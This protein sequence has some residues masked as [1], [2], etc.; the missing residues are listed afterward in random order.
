MSNKTLSILIV[1]TSDVLGGA[2][3]TAYRLHCG[4]KRHGVQSKMF[5]KNKISQDD[6]VI[7]L[8]DFLPHQRWYTIIKW[9]GN[10]IMN[11]IQHYHWNKY[12]NKEHV[13][14]SDLRST[15]IHEAFLKIE[16]NIL[17]LHWI[18]LRFL[19]LK[20]LKN[21]NKP[22]VWTLH[23][24]W[25]FTGV[26]HYFYECD[27]YTI[28]CG[29]C[30]LLHSQNNGDLSHFVWEK[31]KE[32]YLGLN[33]HI[34]APSRWLGEAA[35]RSSLFREFPVSVIPNPIDSELFSPGDRVN[36]C[37]MLELDD[38]KTYVLYCAMNAVNDKNKGFKQLVD[39]VGW[40][41]DNYNNDDFVLLV[42]GSDKPEID[43]N[44]PID[45]QYLG[46]INE[47][48]KMV[49]AYRSASVIVV[50]SL[51]ENL[52]NVIME[53]LSCGTPV[54]AFDIGGNSD[55]IDHKENGYLA[56]ALSAEDL[57]SGIYWCLHTEK[58][59]ISQLARK[60]VEENFTMKIVSQQYIDLY[61]SLI[62]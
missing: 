57:A 47:D 25:P 32:Y 23:D 30:P 19:N 7:A 59:K 4:M 37:N 24:C 1:S 60:K 29:N 11:K 10:K 9:L 21:V 13:F 34:V 55:M 62:K 18:N 58:K 53:S 31:K 51:S 50:P 27:R 38:C 48:V 15:S 22:I 36:A 35:V 3:R 6:T 2:S 45:V 52:S 56:E 39:A 42:L 46:M 17:H 33:L 61:K 40:Y 28:G 41:S 26:C 44:I 43:F 14:M 16:F 20:M 49:S 54:V 8:S 5:V 12:P